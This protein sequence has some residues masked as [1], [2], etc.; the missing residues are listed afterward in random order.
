MSDDYQRVDLKRSYV[1]GVDVAIPDADMAVVQEMQRGLM[2]ELNRVTFE[3]LYGGSF[4][5]T[6]STPSPFDNTIILSPDDYRVVDEDEP[7]R[8]E[9]PPCTAP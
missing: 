4:R 8:L 6:S 3:A 9:L 2:D 1:I 5:T 7:Q